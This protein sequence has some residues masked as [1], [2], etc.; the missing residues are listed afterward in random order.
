VVTE[1][2]TRHP[3]HPRGV[4]ARVAARPALGTAAFPGNYSNGSRR[5]PPRHLTRPGLEGGERLRRGDGA[6][7]VLAEVP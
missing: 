3:E 1:H 5:F 6:V 2:H 4:A 7:R